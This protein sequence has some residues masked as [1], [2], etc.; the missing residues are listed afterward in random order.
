MRQA[1][2]AS[3][4]SP[5]DLDGAWRLMLALAERARRGDA[6]TTDTCFAARDGAFV[7][8]TA[9]LAREGV[10]VAPA[11]VAVICAS[12]LPLDAQVERL[13][14]L[15]LP[16][17]VGPG[18]HALVVGHL[19]Q[20]LDGRVATPT[21]VSQFITGSEDVR[22][23]HRL[24]ALF[25]A[26]LVG[27]RTVQLD[28]P[29]LTTRLAEGPH[30]TRVVLDPHAK[31]V[32]PRKLLDDGEADTL[33]CTD[34][35]RMPTPLRRGGVTYLGIPLRNGQFD[36][37]ALREALAARDLRRLF[38]EGG[39][40]TISRMLAAGMLDRLHVGVAPMILGS[41]APAFALPPIDRLDEALSVRCRHFS[42]GDDVLFDC[43]LRG[44]PLAAE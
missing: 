18:A 38:V 7:P 34:L 25:D 9:P 19:G 10:V 39:G 33:I 3:Q 12:G 30:P 31:L 4:V 37:A 14:A 28:D 20:S 13:C 23:T 32:P 21:G 1:P 26:V 40:V 6:V 17:L 29:R 11:R 16:L 35:A 36:L 22:H 5:L 2:A 44:D 42:L 27:V 43:A 8:A 41:G 15:F 24:R